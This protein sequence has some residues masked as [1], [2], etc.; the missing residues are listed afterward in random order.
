MRFGLNSFLYTSPFT[1]DSVKLFAK[2]KKWGFD[3][4]EIPVDG[5]AAH[6]YTECARIWNPIHTDLAVALAADLP[7]LI[8]HGTA[9]LAHGVS[10]GVRHLA[11]GD[12]RAM[13]RI[14]GRFGSMV[15]MPGNTPIS[16]PRKQPMKQYQRFCQDR[17]TEKPR[18]RFLKMPGST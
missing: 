1:T 14:R 12:P 3:T 9:T 6:T 2:F 8:L 13:V 7:G 10:V 5:G 18:I 16:V 11:G 4:V 15:P 17:A